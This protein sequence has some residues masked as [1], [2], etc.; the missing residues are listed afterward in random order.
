MLF[1]VLLLHLLRLSPTLQD[2]AVSVDVLDADPGGQRQRGVCPHPVHDRPQLR[3]EG[4]Q[5]EATGRQTDG[6]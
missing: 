4:N 1:D 5:A 3:Q 2:E 6:R